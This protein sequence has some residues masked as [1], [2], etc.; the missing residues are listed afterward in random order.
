MATDA[1]FA[2]Y[3]CDQMRGAGAIT[4]RK[5]FGEYAVYCDGKVVALICDNQLFVKP[6]PG[7]RAL[8]G[9]VTEAPPYPGAKPCFLL[10]DALDDPEELA[11]LIRVTAR[12]LPA[13]RPKGRKG[14]AQKRPRKN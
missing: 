13:P 2:A 1:D 14:A 7:G 6:T 12:E 8:L 11:A 5:M 10:G 3:V 9:T 4:S